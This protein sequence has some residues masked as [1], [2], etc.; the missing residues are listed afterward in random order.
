MSRLFVFVCVN[1]QVGLKT[2]ARSRTNC[3]IGLVIA[4][5]GTT[6]VNANARHTSKLFLCCH[7]FSIRLSKD[8]VPCVA[9]VSMSHTIAGCLGIVQEGGLRFPCV[10]FCQGVELGQR[11][12]HPCGLQLH[13][14][15][16]TTIRASVKRESLPQKQIFYGVLLQ[17]VSKRSVKGMSDWLV[18]RFERL[19]IPVY[20]MLVAL[21]GQLVR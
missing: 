6:H 2:K 9:Y 7:C 10:R 20:L 17:S 5:D 14:P 11:E 15:V 4:G 12:V 1:R 18:K 8:G 21:Q 19:N 16:S 13:T 3:D